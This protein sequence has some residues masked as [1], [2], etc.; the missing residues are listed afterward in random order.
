MACRFAH[1]WYEL[2]R[3]AVA[4]QDAEA[5]RRHLAECAECR[6]RADGVRHVAAL[7]EQLAAP[8]RT[9]LSEAAAALLLHRARTRGLLG[10]TPKAAVARPTRVRWRRVGVP[11]AAS[12]AAMVLAAIGIRLWMPEDIHPRGALERLVRSA[13]GISAAAS[14]QPLA[15]VARAAVSAELARRQPDADQVADLLLVAY[16]CQNP[17]ENRQAADVNFI[18]GIVWDRRER[19]TDTAAAPLPT[20]PML[21]SAASALAKSAPAVDAVTAAKACLLEG[22]Y[23]GALAALPKDV[24]AAA[25]RAWCLESLGRPADAGLA[26]A[27]D[28]T[29]GVLARVLQADLALAGKNVVEALRQYET[30]AAQ[31]DR[32]WFMSGYLFRYELCDGRSAGERFEK[33]RDKALAEYVAEAFSPELSMAKV[34]EPPPLFT[35]DWERFALG[36]PTEMALVL[37]RGGEFRVVEVPG[38]KALAQ[39]EIKSRGAEFLAGGADWSDYTTRFDV[40]VLE[41]N[42]G[43]YAI[44]AAACR[45]P[46][47]TGYVLELS[48]A[49][50]RILKQFAVAV[51]HS[52]KAVNAGAAPR[53]LMILQPAQA[54]ARLDEALALGWWYTLE[55]RVQHVGDGM[56]VT[57][58]VWR[59]DLKEPPDWQVVWTDAGRGGGGSFAAG[60]TGVQISGARV[61]I[62]NFVVTRNEAARSIAAAAP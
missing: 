24:T 57:G 15:P 22:D 29:S 1:E 2:E 38:G 19:R 20:W 41:T 4:R 35:E 28:R 33:V 40:K 5:L 26:L 31:K 36:P 46:G 56:A 12:I 34:P 50:L 18:L 16:I 25:L 53:E 9:D 10:K 11:L 47:H 27:Q 23:K 17:R 21:A 3:G 37:T 59:S 54:Q 55:I 58:K 61:L 6:D 60:A 8:T 7:L 39:E 52:R 51:E 49:G 42:K 45:Q 13:H 44:G 32:Y 62:D 48:S 43:G 14:L 30:L